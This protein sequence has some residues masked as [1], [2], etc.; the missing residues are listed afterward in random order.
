LV[1]SKTTH[2]LTEFAS[3]K[4]VVLE[5]SIAS[6]GKTP[7]FFLSVQMQMLGAKYFGAGCFVP[8]QTTIVPRSMRKLVL[9][10]IKHPL[11]VVVALFSVDPQLTLQP[12]TATEG[13]SVLTADLWAAT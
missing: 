13:K 11:P 9:Q 1:N 6:S 4:L 5:K 3:Y 8:C 2:F 12:Q 10:S 7:G